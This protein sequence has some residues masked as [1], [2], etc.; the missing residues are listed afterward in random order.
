MPRS[1]CSSL[2]M[3][4]Q[5]ISHYHILEKLGGGGMGVVYKAEDTRL[6]RFVALKF[7]PENLA[8]DHQALERFQREAQAASALDHPNICTIYEIGEHEGQPFICMQFLDGRTLK[9]LIGGK[10][11]PL[12]HLLDLAIQ[13]CDALD[14]AHAKGIIHRDIK[15]ANIFVTKRGH[16]K[17][18]DFGLAKLVPSPRVAEGVGVS[19]MPTETGEELLTSPG[20]AVGTVAYMS[21]EQVWGKELDA[22][23]DLFSF[24]VVLYELAT[25]ALPFRGGTS[26]VIFDAILNRAPVAPVRLNPDVPPKL[27]EIINRALEKDRGLRYQHSSDLRAELQRLKRDTDSS[28]SSAAVGAMEMPAPPAAAD[29]M[30]ARLRSRRKLGT[31]VA[32]AAATM[33][34]T[35]VYW[36]ERP[37]QPPKVI[38]FHQLTQDGALKFAPILTDGSRI[39]FGELARSEW[40]LAE[41]STVGGETALVKTPFPFATVLDISPDR[42]A[43]LV[44][45]SAGIAALETPLWI[46][47]VP[48]GAP[49]RVG[50]LVAESAAWSPDG[51]RI[52]YGHGNDL[53]LSKGDGSD[54]KKL[55]TLTGRAEYISWSQ[56][57]HV[58]RFTVLDRGLRNESLW[59][60]S[61]N[62]NNLHPFL[63]GWN[64]PS[65]EC[66]GSWTPDG[67]YFVFTSTRNDKTNLWAVGEGGG[68]FDRTKS[69]PIQL[70]FGPTQMFGGTPSLDGKKL[71]AIGSQDRGELYRF[72][73]KAGQFLPFLPGI[74]ANALDFS[75]DG[76]WLAYA[77]YPDSTL[78]R[79]K[80]DGTEKVQLSFPPLEAFIPKWSRD[81]RWIAFAARGAG[82][83]WGLYLIS[84]D[85][86]NPQLLSS[87]DRTEVQ[88]DWSPEGNTI[89]F[90]GLPWTDVSPEKAT[91]VQLLDLKTNQRST[92]PGSEGF[93][94]PRWSPDGR[95]IVALTSDSSKLMLFDFKMRKWTVLMSMGNVSNPTWSRDGRFLYFDAP[96]VDDP[97]IYRIGL[98]DRKVER[99]VSLK[100]FRLVSMFFPTMNLTPDGS[101][102]LLRNVGI[103]EVYALDLSH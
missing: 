45:A 86:G 27:E 17:I 78:W 56:D 14:A 23:T 75:R 63:P 102:V 35:G 52:A 38:A 48:A 84:R 100:D 11:V 66:C 5:T 103:Q 24:G 64:M 12:E 80:A 36:L 33:L 6:H 67:K 39:Y 42:S 59:E 60:V 4:G 29:R 41:V 18:L 92:L 31:I 79:S 73:A 82:K 83:T 65:A 81:A 71:F 51:Q 2:V 3:I 54:A 30:I 43:L 101:P 37:A 15:P 13:I 97:A 76:Q 88:P 40:G 34:M 91:S 28:R 96:F 50:D 1:A 94:A 68:I 20:M 72:D 98:S 44:G 93:Y 70:T 22:R 19:A 47:P 9:H 89:A 8:R 55:V 53:Y 90:S 58:L 46:L 99:L 21:P 26:G 10:P 57:G 95:Y 25:G 62:G 61:A 32:A 7:L 49:R 16:P 77:S 85:G 69:Q 74:P 87:P